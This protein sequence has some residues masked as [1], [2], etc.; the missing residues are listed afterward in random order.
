MAAPLSI[1]IKEERM[2]VFGF[3]YLEGMI[4]ALDT[5]HPFHHNTLNEDDSRGLVL[6]D[7]LIIR[8]HIKMFFPVSS[9]LS[10]R[11]SCFTIN[12]SHHTALACDEQF[13]KVPHFLQRQNKSLPSYLL[14]ADRQFSCHV[15]RSPTLQR[16]RGKKSST[17]YRIVANDPSFSAGY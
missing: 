4:P 6:M 2:A 3:F 12:I 5:S 17:L 14:D 8:H 15:E 16:L 11:R 13:P 7:C 10:I 1:C 9:A